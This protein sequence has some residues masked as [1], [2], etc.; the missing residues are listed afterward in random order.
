MDKEHYSPVCFICK[1]LAF[2]ML[3]CTNCGETPI[4]E[5][6]AE[7]QMDKFV[8]LCGCKDKELL[9]MLLDADE[10]YCVT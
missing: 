5:A 9:P 2:P 4:C 8:C 3:V 6:C 7:T 1:H 10:D